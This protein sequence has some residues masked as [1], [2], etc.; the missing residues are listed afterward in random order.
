MEGAG[1]EPPGGE[2]VEAKEV[3]A[4]AAPAYVTVLASSC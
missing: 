4:V 1:E 3:A 2:E